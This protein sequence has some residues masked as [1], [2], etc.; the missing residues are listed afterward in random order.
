[1][2]TSK[3][4]S[5]DIGEKL[6]HLTLKEKVSL[7][8]GKNCWA[9]MP[10]ERLAIPQLTLTDGPHGVRTVKE[11]P[12][13]TK[14]PATAFPTGIS[15]AATWN[16]ALVERV[17][18]AL[19]R[20]TLAM[21]CQVLLGPCVNI[22]RHPLAGRNFESYSEDPFLAGAIGS[23]YVKGV[24]DLGVAVSLKHF[25]CNNQEHERQRGSSELDERTLREI[26]LA[27]FEMIV[28]SSRPWTVMC[29]YNRINGTYAGENAR[30]LT[31]IL[32]QEWGFDGVVISDWGA[33]HSTVA[34]IK[35]GLDI[36]MPG[37]AKY[38]GKF[39]EDALY[40]WQLEHTDVEAA[41]RRI[42]GLIRRC[43]PQ[44]NKPGKSKPGINVKQHQRLARSVAE[45]SIV[46]LK[47]ESLL[48]LKAGSLK[49]LAVIGPNAAEARLGGGGSAYVSPPYKISPLEALKRQLAGKTVLQ[50]TKGCDNFVE[51]PVVNEQN[52]L[53]PDRKTPGLKLSIFNNTNVSGKPAG[54][55]IDPNIASWWWAGDPPAPGIDFYTFS[56]RWSGYLRVDE[57]ADYT[58]ELT[59]SYRCFVFV[60]DTRIISQKAQ[61][62]GQRETTRKTISLTGGK[63]HKLRVT[64]I[65]DSVEGRLAYIVFKMA[66]LLPQTEEPIREA[67]DLAKTSDAAVIFA[68]LPE[69]FERE[70][71]DRP[72]MDLPG[73]Q[74]ELIGK[75]ASVNANTVVVLNCGAQ[76]AMP[77]VNL[78]AAIVQAHY[79]GMEGGNALADILLGKVT[80]SGKLTISYPAGLADSPAYPFY[81]GDR[82]V[83]Y[84]EGIFVGYRYFDAVDKEPLFPFGH[85]LSYTQFRY[86]KLRVPKS[87]RIG[88]AVKVK[89]DIEN[90]GR[91]AGMEVVQ[92]YVRDCTASVLR[93][94]KELKGF[95]KLMLKP[96]E[97]Q[98][99]AFELDFR[100][101]AFYD[102]AAAAWRV[103]PGKFEIFVGSSSRDIR[104]KSTLEVI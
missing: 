77:W 81:P 28:K 44:V 47:N 58:I 61:A 53:A 89:I 22:I 11:D 93:P 91:V 51:L 43:L 85:G 73:R 56:C 52:L 42:L 21:G 2:S 66:R 18:N 30:L 33:N 9:T 1:M 72:H 55:R 95:S 70:G 96:G 79:P 6:R 7:L 62:P 14:G 12:E 10:V 54:E 87:A 37:P 48:P 15:I 69:N 94:P 34:S 90:I 50:Y 65:R 63:L 26:Y 49:T 36:E 24:Q 82:K 104:A 3:R 31:R 60:D 25:A 46:V 74:N 75:V 86:S 13:R 84:G 67:L 103:E 99:A 76:V 78:P 17:G 32:R 27:Q 39:V 4:A 100:S 19:A 5:F 102:E 80:P 64:Y 101:F 68:G 8:S 41:V 57:N 35:A 88:V 97:K 59:N 45:E 83:H 71:D 20:E 92:L 40:N 23:A 98:S 38:Y 16:T 29:S